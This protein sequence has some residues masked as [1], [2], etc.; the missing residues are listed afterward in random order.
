MVEVMITTAIISILTAVLLV[1][2]RGLQDRRA[3]EGAAREVTA[4][5]REAQNYSLTGRNI[6]GADDVPCRFQFRIGGTNMM[7][8][9][10]S[11][12]GD[13]GSFGAAEMVSIGYDVSISQSEAVQF[14]VPRGEPITS[15]F[16]ELDASD[17]YVQF[18]ISRGSLTRYVCIYSMGRVEERSEACSS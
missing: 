4:G 15:S 9:E 12:A 10:Q 13:C 16:G 3:V 7:Y 14:Q 18:S 5:I 6:G 11:N 8:I 17:E 2:M 1:N